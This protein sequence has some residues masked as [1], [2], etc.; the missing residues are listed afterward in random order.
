MSVR[1]RLFLAHRFAGWDLHD[2]PGTAI[3]AQNLVITVT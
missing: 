3:F 1:Q 2:T